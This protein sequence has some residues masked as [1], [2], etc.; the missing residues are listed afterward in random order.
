MRQTRNLIH[1]F[2]ASSRP[3]PL[4]PLSSKRRD[5]DNYREVSVAFQMLDLRQRA[6]RTDAAV[7]E[8]PLEPAMTSIRRILVLLDPALLPTPA[9]DRAV[10]LA[11]AFKAELWLGLFDTGPRLGLWGI[12]DRKEA[13]HLESLMRDQESTRLLDLMRGLQDRTGL[14]LRTVDHRGRPRADQIVEQ[15][16]EHDI[17]LVI[18]DVGHDSA[19]R[20][21]IFLPLDWELLRTS[22]VPVWL[23]SPRATG[24]PR[25]LAVA[26]DPVHPEHGAGKLNNALLETARLVAAPGKARLRIFSAFAGLPVALNTL[27]PQAVYM[28]MPY[29]ELYERLWADHREAFDTLLAAHRLPADS[30]EVLVGTPEERLLDAL[31]TYQP[32]VLILGT[33]RRHGL[34]RLLLGSTAERIIG[35]ASCDV[36]TV[37]AVLAQPVPKIEERGHPSSA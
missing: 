22:P 15:V 30:G 5:G 37:P 2:V 16:I 18:K 35:K 4:S 12:M 26:V 27:D 33:M 11:T 20:R 6:E 10:A 31:D 19:L 14:E 7:Y 32:D 23:A 3:R 8:S 24:L 13:E 1:R 34:D 28:A 25:R 17:D 29:D 9:L 36:L 21:L